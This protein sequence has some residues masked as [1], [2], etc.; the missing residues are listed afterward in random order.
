M[1]PLKASH[2]E[3]RSIVIHFLRAKGLSANAIHNR[4]ASSVWWHVF[5]ETNNTCFM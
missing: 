2:K 3:L 1:L 5:Y 4:D